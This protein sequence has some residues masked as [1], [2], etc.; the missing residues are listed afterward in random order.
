MLA[1]SLPT[2]SYVDP[3]ADSH[4][5]HRLDVEHLSGAHRVGPLSSF[6]AA[7]DL[8]HGVDIVR[9]ISDSW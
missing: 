6:I 4:T 1:L 3:V 8:P 5:K 9:H 7:K 2:Q